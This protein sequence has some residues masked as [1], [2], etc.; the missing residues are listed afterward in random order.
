MRSLKEKIKDQIED[1]KEDIT[2]YYDD[3]DNPKSTNDRLNRQYYLMEV[4]RLEQSI[5][6]LEWVLTEMEADENE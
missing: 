2:L 5:T 4:G 1:F 3:I 6:V